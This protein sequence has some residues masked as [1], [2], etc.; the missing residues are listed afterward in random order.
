MIDF[1]NKLP[2]AVQQ[3]L[4]LAMVMGILVVANNLMAED[5]SWDDSMRGIVQGVIVRALSLVG[6]SIE[7]KP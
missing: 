2:A 3:V 1:W 7:R 6:I 4:L 5:P